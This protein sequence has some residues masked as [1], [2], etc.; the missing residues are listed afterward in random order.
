VLPPAARSQPFGYPDFTLRISECN[1]REDGWEE[2]TDGNE[3]TKKKKIGVAVLS[4]TF[5]VS[6]TVDFWHGYH[7]S[8]S[9][10]LGVISAIGGAVGGV[11]LILS[12][13]AGPTNDR[14]NGQDSS[15]TLV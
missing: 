6:V 1:H 10:P 2:K 3:M 13:W 11:L 9:I 12:M 5:L 14:P 15:G 7:R 8:R 4:V